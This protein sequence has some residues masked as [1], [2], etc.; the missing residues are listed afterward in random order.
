MDDQSI[1]AIPAGKWA[2]GVSGGADSVALLLLLHRRP[3]LQLHV[4]H[5]DHETRNGQSAHDAAFV[6]DLAARLHLPATITLRS[7]VNSP[8]LK[9]LSAKFRAARIA[10][11]KQVVNSQQLNGVILAHHADDQAETVL[12]RLLRGA[13]PTAL[14][15]MSP[16]TTI[17]GL[18]ILR[19]LLQIPSSDLRQFLKNQNQPWQQDISNTSPKY[20]R[21]RLRPILAADPALRNSLLDLAAACRRLRQWLRKNAPTL[22]QQFSVDVLASLPPPLARQS[23]RR[24]FLDRNIPPGRITTIACDRLI[25]MAADAASPPRQHFPA[26]LLVRRRRGIIT[27]PPSS[28]AIPS[29]PPPP[30]HSDSA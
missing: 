16:K 22:P 6:A 8:P 9:N 30:L 24:W 19:P 10:L 5:L 3:D 17:D 20:L 23:A 28:A 25:A 7:Q 4:V 26:G 11:F 2:V 15:G 13:G 1:L 18:C 14:T 29:V 21:N 12:Q 27:G